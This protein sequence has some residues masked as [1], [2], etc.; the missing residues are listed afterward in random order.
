MKFFDDALRR[1][2]KLAAAG[3]PVVT[4]E[5]LNE[6]YDTCNQCEHFNGWICSEM[7]CCSRRAYV[8]RYFDLVLDPTKK[9]PYSPTGFDKLTES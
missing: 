3:I 6:R 2:N 1:R 9:C 8:V 5:Q 7:G 4:L